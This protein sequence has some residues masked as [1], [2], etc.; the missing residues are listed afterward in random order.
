MPRA[1]LPPSGVPDV[2]IVSAHTGS[3]HHRDELRRSAECGCFYCLG[4]YPPDLIDEWVDDGQTALC[5]E[6]GIDSV[7][8]SASGYPIE[9]DFL[10]RMR[11]H[12]FER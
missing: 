3:D 2:D 9:T 5:P 8:G 1:K 7:I 11:E 10:Q 6:C 4:I 12:W